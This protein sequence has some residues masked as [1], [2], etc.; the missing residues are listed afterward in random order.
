MQYGGEIISEELKYSPSV[1][2]H[3]TA[4]F[5][6]ISPQGVSTGIVLSP[7]SSIGPTEFIIPP[8]VFNLAKS[9]L[10]FQLQIDAQA[11]TFFPYVDANLLTTISR[12]VLYDSNTNAVWCDV[13]NFEKYAS[14]VVPAAT[15]Y[16]DFKTKATAWQSATFC[17]T[18]A[19]TSAVST[20]FACEDIQK[21]NSLLNPTHL[22]T[23]AAG[24]T[25]FNSYEGRRYL[26][27]GG[28]AD[29]VTANAAAYVDV[30]LPLSA[31]KFTAL[32]VNKNLANMSNLV[33]QIYWNSLDNFAFKGTS[34]TNPTTG[35]VSLTANCQL[36]NVALE[37]CNEQNLSIISKIT[38][39]VASSGISIPIGYPT[40]TRQVITSANPSYTLNISKG[41]GQ[42]ILAFITA[43]FS[44]GSVLKNATNSHIRGTLTNYQTTMNNIAIKYQNGFNC[45]NG[46][47][48]YYGNREYL[49][50]STIQ[51]N[52]EYAVA[53]WVHIDS[54]FGER[55]LH[56]VEQTEID[57]YD[58]G[59]TASAWQ[60]QGTLSASAQT[61]WITAII[62]QKL[63]TLSANGSM[64]Q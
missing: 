31:F 26:L 25:A 44:V 56:E 4:A 46:E 36:N 20:P 42:R 50:K 7:S 41:Y 27:V 1:Q 38:Q 29:A 3:S 11:A 55:P 60:F 8:S 34:V 37:L 47:D 21:S 15:K 23:A 12:V 52:Q 33:L 59:S 39:Q 18:L 9:R 28:G 40:T 54:Y 19:T 62:G 64:V 35:A 16:D 14:M 61:F 10:N 53:E 17:Q 51:S 45:V 49:E 32:A 5:R 48:W 13:S 43:P 57:G 2:N 30:S 24:V 22:G 58:V 63:L 6:K